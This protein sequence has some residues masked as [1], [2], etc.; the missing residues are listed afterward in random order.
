MHTKLRDGVFSVGVQDPDLRIF[1]IVMYTKYGTTYN[2]YLVIGSEKIA[3]IENVKYK[4]FEQF[5][6][7]IKEIISP[8]KIDYLII[9]HTEPDH[10]GSIEKLLELNPNIK[11]FGSSTAIKFLKKITNKDF[12]FQVVNHNDQ[13]SL[14]NKTLR[15]I[16]APFLHWPDSIYTYLVEDKILFT[17]DSFGCHFSTENLDINWVMQNDKE[18]FMDA[19]KYYY[20]VIMSPF[21]SYVLQAIDKIKDLEIDIIAPG[22]GPILTNYKDDLISLYKSWSEKLSEKPSK[23]YVVIVYVSAYGYTEMLAKKI[24][25][26]IQ[27]SGVD[28]LVYNAI[29]HKPEEIV[30]KIYFASGVLFGSPTINS[31]ALPPIYEILIRLNPIVHGGKVAAAFGSYGWSGEAV[32]NIESRLKQIRLK[33]VLPGLKV[34]FKPNEEELKKSFEF[35]ILFAEK[36]K[37]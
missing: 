3:L 9:N 4:F 19:Y 33:V 27:Q 28:V 11:V 2:S 15:F 26:G 6:D 14:G 21:K 30:E 34:N 22:H 16:S 35:G 13:I 12:E 1:D 25:E 20:N 36:I 8:E 23:P 7:N 32:P 10:S 17:C 18:G 29:E 37:E 24:A 5:L 31:D